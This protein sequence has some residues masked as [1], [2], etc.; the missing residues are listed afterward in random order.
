MTTDTSLPLSRFF[1]LDLTHARAGPNAARQLADW[2]A[3][4]VKIEPPGGNDPGVAGSDRHG[5]DFQNLHRNKRAI[6]LDLKHP[7]G[8]KVF[9]RLI[10]RTDVLVE[11]FRPAVKHRLGIDYDNLRQI[12]PRLVY[13]SISGF[14]QDGPYGDRP[15]FDQIA[16][17]MGGLMSVTGIPGQ[18]PVRVGIPVADLSAGLY[19]AQ[20]I[21]VALLEREVSGQGQ[22]VKTSLLQAMIAMMDFQ[23]S[24]W[25]L[26][27]EV[28]PQAGN[29]HPTSIPTGVFKTS[30]GHINL[31][32]SGDHMWERLCYA[33]ELDH[34]VN[35]PRFLTG[36]DRS[37]NRAAVNAA[38]GGKLREHPSEHWVKTLNE[39][40]VPCGP[41]YAMNE[42][43]ADPQV[44]HLGIAAPV[45]HPELGQQQLVNQPVSLS[46]T[47]GGVRFSSPDKGQ[48]TDA[49]LSEFGYS[50]SEIAE[51]RKAGAI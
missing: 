9:R 44:Q 32:A 14:G 21:L 23:A 33:L 45:M 30:D 36:K 41:I 39:V 24:R 28:P 31:A 4:V 5:S 34:L 17:G 49:V 35:D 6:T 11:N 10:E 18:G 20:G 42:V 12:N 51:L 37:R 48:D 27:Q 7:E 43:F 50:S 19:L 25:L 8:A 16:Q 38:L 26:D 1:V 29:D 13:G 46:R 3:R 40:G 22:W 47:P 15:G 2:G